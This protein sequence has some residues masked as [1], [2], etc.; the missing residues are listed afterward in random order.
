M[1]TFLRLRRL[2]DF[3]VAFCGLR[4][5][6][7][8]DRLTHLVAQLVKFV[9]GAKHEQLLQKSLKETLSQLLERVNEGKPVVVS[10]R[11]FSTWICFTDGACEER[12]SVGAILVSPW[13]KAVYAFGS[14]L[15]PELH[16]TFY[17]DS[18]HPIYEVE[19]LPVL[20]SVFLWRRQ[21]EQCQIVY[22]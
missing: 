20:I 19:L 21:I 4:I 5:S 10:P 9:S 18:Q 14:E 22:T 3:V 17:S 8:G 1:L 2:R 7:V 11:V 16:K 12:A 6:C 15:P 13:G